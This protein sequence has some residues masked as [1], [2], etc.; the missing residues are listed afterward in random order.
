MD[1][2]GRPFLI[3]VSQTPVQVFVSLTAKYQFTYIRSEVL[4]CS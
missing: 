3:P 1:I 2:Y 4:D